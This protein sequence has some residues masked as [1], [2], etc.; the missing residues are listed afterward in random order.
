MGWAYIQNSITADMNDVH[1]NFK[2]IR[3]GSILPKKLSTS[4]SYTDGSYNIGSS[5]YR[6]KE[7]YINSIIANTITASDIFLNSHLQNTQILTGVTNTIIFTLTTAQTQNLI[8]ILGFVKKTAGVVFFANS[9]GSSYFKIIATT[10]AKYGLFSL[11]IKYYTSSSN[12][13]YFL[14]AGSINNTITSLLG[15]MTY[16]TDNLS[17]SLTSEIQIK[18]DGNFLTGTTI[19]L[20]YEK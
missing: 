6:W 4:L 20:Y 18:T 7:L 17:D 3:D 12:R 11:K 14:F 16:T 2:V 1:E 13:I 5:T 19:K 8:N 15:E 9:S 10:S